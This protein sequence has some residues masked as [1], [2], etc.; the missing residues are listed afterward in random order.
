M[1]YYLLAPEASLSRRNPETFTAL[2]RSQNSCCMAFYLL[3]VLGTVSQGVSNST[4]ITGIEGRNLA[5]DGS[6]FP[7]QAS[8]VSASFA[9]VQK[10]K[11]RLAYVA[12]LPEC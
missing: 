3:R 2:Q 1:S 5:E 9:A 8:F 11:C 4:K 6:L 12:V 7:L 10:V